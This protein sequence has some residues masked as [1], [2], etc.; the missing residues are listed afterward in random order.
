HPAP[1]PHGHHAAP[2]ARNL[3]GNPHPFFPESPALSEC[4]QLRMARGEVCTGE[5]GGL[6]DLSDALMAPRPVTG[7]HNLAKAI[8][9]PT[10][11]GLG[12]VDEA[13]GEVR[14]RL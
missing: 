11:V 3:L 5:H 1:P 6:A 13:E 9:R 12:I 7:Y 14:Q 8:D 10:I 4:A 2:G